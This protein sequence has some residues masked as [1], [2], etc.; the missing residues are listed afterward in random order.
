VGIVPAAT[1]FA[2]ILAPSA[3]RLG[4][5]LDLSWP[6]VLGLVLCTLPA[7]VF[8]APVVRRWWAGTP[9]QRTWASLMLAAL[10]FSLLLRL[11]GTWPFFTVDKTSYLLWIPWALAG[12]GA[13]AAWTARCV[14]EPPSCRL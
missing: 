4:A 9:A 2:G 11:P 12:S 1:Y 6:R 10:A 5:P 8:G 13:W 7:L 14:I 3:T